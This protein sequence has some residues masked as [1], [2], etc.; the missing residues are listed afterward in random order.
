MACCAGVS[1]RGLGSHVGVF[2]GTAP[3]T[4][5]PSRNGT[6]SHIS[7]RKFISQTRLGCD[8]LM[9]CFVLKP[10]SALKPPYLIRCQQGEASCDSSKCSCFIKW[11]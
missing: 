8:L 11:F 9:S 4:L 5:L 10:P 3:G 6:E 7:A 2:P 1:F